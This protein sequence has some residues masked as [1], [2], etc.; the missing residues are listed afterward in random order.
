MD[1][2]AKLRLVGGGRG[3]G[4]CMPG[5]GDTVY[6]KLVCISCGLASGD[7]LNNNCIGEQN[8]CFCC[9]QVANLGFGGGSCPDG[10]CPEWGCAGGFRK[11][12][13]DASLSF[14][15]TALKVGIEIPSK[16]LLV[17]CGKQ[18]A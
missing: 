9:Q 6:T 4:A 7:A 2:S 17:V 18:I 12:D 1:E 10:C 8:S 15:F 16:P 14:K 5:S 3:G 13:G 11:P